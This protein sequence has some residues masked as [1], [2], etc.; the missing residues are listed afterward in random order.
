MY[1]FAVR[2]RWLVGHFVVLLLAGSFVLAGFWQLDRLHQVR[3]QNDLIRAR[4]QLPA[5]GLSEIAAATASSASRAVQRKVEVVGRFDPSHEAI[6]FHALDGR[7]GFDVLTPLVTSDG[8]AVIVDRGWVP[9]EA[10]MDA[11]PAEARSPSAEVRVVGFALPGDSGGDI[12]FSS[13]TLA[14]INRIDLGLLQERMPFD[15]FPVYV[16][17][18]RQVPAQASGLPRPV[19]PPPLDNG[20]HLSYAIQWFT[21]TA[22]GLIGWPLLLRKAARDR[23]R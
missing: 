5:V 16:R 1:R 10:A 3:A 11:L 22:I 20:P 7:T 23:A 12:A 19:P 21:F 18:T 8:S 2:G 9:G 17:L 6:E 15:L 13:G 4:R 14:E